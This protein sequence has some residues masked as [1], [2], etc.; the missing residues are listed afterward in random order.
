MLSTEIMGNYKTKTVYLHR[1]VAQE[2]LGRLLHQGEVV[3]HISKDTQDNHPDN[4]EVCS[5]KYV[6]QQHHK[7]RDKKI[8]KL[9]EIDGLWF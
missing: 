2:M 8:E 9:I 4:L 3:H 6:H 1:F 7:K 5:S